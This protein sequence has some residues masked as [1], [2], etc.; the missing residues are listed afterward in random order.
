MIQYAVTRK[1]QDWAV[2]QGGEAIA[3]GLSRSA[4]I[5]M[6]QRLVFEAEGRGE[7]VEFLTQGYYGDLSRRFSG[8]DAAG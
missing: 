8:P 7:A 1:G 5:E 3:Q 2:F 4:A 6:A